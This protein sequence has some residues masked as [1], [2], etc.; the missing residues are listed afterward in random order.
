MTEDTA[1]KE[2]V[3]EKVEAAKG[4]KKEKIAPPKGQLIHHVIRVISK[5]G[6]GEGGSWNASE[7]EEYL[8]QY[9]FNGWILHSTHYLDKA[10]EG[11]MVM[12]VLT[13]D[14]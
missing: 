13:K 9:T 1:V 4:E 2:E 10:P 14:Q 12:W 6:S 7:I 11:Y 5:D 3:K 8:A